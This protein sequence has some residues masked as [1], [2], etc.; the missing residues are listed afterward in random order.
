MSNGVKVQAYGRSGWRVSRNGRHLGAIGYDGTQIVSKY[1]WTA[2]DPSGQKVSIHLGAYGWAKSRK[3]A[4]ER[5][6][7]WHDANALLTIA[8]VA[9]EPR[10]QKGDCWAQPVGLLAWK[11]QGL[12]LHRDAGIIL[13]PIGPGLAHKYAWHPNHAE[14]TAFWRLRLPDDILEER[15]P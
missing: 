6:C 9:K 5:L 4:V 1:Q 15:E 12:T 2:H 8:D 10:F 13:V 3:A 11:G 14:L 7:A